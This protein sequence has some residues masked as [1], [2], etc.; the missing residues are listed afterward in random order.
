[1]IDDT[2]KALYGRLARNPIH[3]AGALAMM[4]NWDLHAL[5]RQ[6]P[7]LTVPLL[8]VAAGNDG[9]IAS[10]D[11]FKTRDLVPGAAVEYARGLGHLAHEERPQEIAAIVTRFAGAHSVL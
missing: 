10:T 9:T 1:M 2:G 11:A 8:L 7:R 3:V 5:Q 4:A 6:L